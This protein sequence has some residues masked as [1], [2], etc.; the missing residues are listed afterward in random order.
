MTGFYILE[1]EGIG[2]RYDTEYEAVRPV[3][4][5][6]PRCPLCG[7]PVD[8]RE[9]LP[10]FKVEITL[11]G[12][13]FGDFCFESPADILV[14]SRLADAFRQ[15]GLRGLSG[16]EPV[17][18]VR[19]KRAGKKTPPI[20]LHVTIARS[21]AAVDESR[22]NIRRTKPIACEECRNPRF[23]AVS[24]FRIDEQTWSGED[25][26][27]L[28]GVAG[29]VVVTKRFRHLVERH[30]FTNARFTPIEDYAYDPYDFSMLKSLGRSQKGEEPKRDPLPPNLRVVGLHKLPFDPAAFAADV[31]NANAES[32]E[33]EAM[34]AEQYRENW[35]NAWLVVVA[36]N[37]ED[38]HIDIDRFGHGP[39]P[40]HA[41]NQA[42]WLEAVLD[43]PP[44][45]SRVGFYLHYVQPENGLWYGD[46][47]LDLPP[48]TPAPPELL[49]QMP[50]ESPD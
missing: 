14:S 1:D 49:R 23:D 8:R 41:Y 48:L 43:A 22:S 44:G 38:T 35:D 4:G 16:F 39:V 31:R 46:Y 9:W 32:P 20:Y 36:C 2:S 25:V 29:D 30:G 17:E 40:G 18:V 33:D 34:W 6:G 45:Q 12:K 37:G 19:V 47:H 24:G 26:F 27:F 5:E 11:F 15:E 21:R 42:P 7:G 28:R 50:Y 13:E 10:P 3:L